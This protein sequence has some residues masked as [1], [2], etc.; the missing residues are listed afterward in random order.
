MEGM[1]GDEIKAG[2]VEVKGES[3]SMEAADVEQI[4]EPVCEVM[5]ELRAAGS[6]ARGKD[7]PLWWWALL[8]KTLG[9]RLRSASYGGQVPSLETMKDMPPPEQLHSVG[10]LMGRVH[11]FLKWHRE[12]V[13][14]K[15][16]PQKTREVVEEMRGRLKPWTDRA[17][18]EVNQFLGRIHTLPLEKVRAFS[19][20][21]AAGLDRGGFDANGD[22]RGGPPYAWL[23]MLMLMAWRSVEALRMQAGG[24]TKLLSAIKSI[25]GGGFRLS[26]KSFAMLC[27]RIGLKLGPVGRPR[28][29]THT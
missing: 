25:M 29:N 23:Y 18:S 2:V 14:W 3:H 17:E 9:I 13:T 11:A 24:G 26:P 20:G 8:E 4:F 28:K 10:E 19:R 22:L 15:E 12:D 16:A 5:P 27:S 6:E 1:N 21:Y 7:F